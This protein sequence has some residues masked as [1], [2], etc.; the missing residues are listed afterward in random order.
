MTQDMALADRLDRLEAQIAPLTQ[1]AKVVSELRD[2]LA[3]RINEAV[4]AL[5]VELADLEPDFQVEDLVFLLK[6]AMRNVKNLN[7]ALDQ[8][9]NIIDFAVIAEPVLKTTIPQIIQYFDDLEQK[10]VFN[11]VSN[12]IEILGKIGTTYTPEQMSQIGDGLVRLVGIAHKLTRPETLDLLEKA[13]DIPANVDVAGA[14]SVGMWGMLS[15]LSRPEVKEGMGV[16]LE[17]TGS[18]ARLKGSR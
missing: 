3:P 11:I 14:K 4:Q 9:K 6:N 17:L 5:I 8:L 16:A 12:G 7:F 15:A 1:S 18:L 10:G 2:E 13:A